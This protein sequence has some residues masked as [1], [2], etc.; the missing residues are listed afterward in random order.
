MP[1]TAVYKV[2]EVKYI[3]T[4]YL[5]REF[6][7]ARTELASQLKTTYNEVKPI[8]GFSDIVGD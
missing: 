3:V 1:K 4:P 7:Q 5:I 2:S 6:E 8:L